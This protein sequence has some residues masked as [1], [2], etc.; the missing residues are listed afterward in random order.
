MSEIERLEDK[1]VQAKERHAELENEAEKIDLRIM[2][3]ALSEDEEEF[4]GAQM[5]GVTLP[6]LLNRASFLVVE[7]E[8]DLV[9]ERKIDALR[10][11]QEAWAR[12]TEMEKGLF[13]PQR[14]KS[15]ELQ[16]AAGRLDTAKGKVDLLEARERELIAEQQELKEAGKAWAAIEVPE[17]Y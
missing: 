17:R 1:L 14:I 8:L 7:T 10:E 16:R 12:Y 5:R 6:F 3:A 11:H 2:E 15:P 9:R 13:P 4:A